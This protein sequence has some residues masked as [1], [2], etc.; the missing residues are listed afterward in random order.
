[1]AAQSPF[2]NS[3][4]FAIRAQQRNLLSYIESFD[5][6]IKDA[7]VEQN[8][9]SYEIHIIDVITPIGTEYR[10]R[11]SNKP[12]HRFNFY[13]FRT[14]LQN[15]NQYT[16]PFDAPSREVS[17][18]NASHKANTTT[19]HD[20]EKQ[21]GDEYSH[22]HTN[23]NIK[24]EKCNCEAPKNA[25]LILTFLLPRKNRDYIL[26]DLDEDFL[27]NIIPDY[28]EKIAK[29]WYWF[30]TIRTILEHNSLTARIINI[31]DAFKKSNGS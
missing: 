21:V 4:S 25:K 12:G 7:R 20:E 13:D 31:I 30:Q 19:K 15:E 16:L 28:G 10:V 24:N 29:R 11:L 27:H 17:N 5:L 23:N 2:K 22:K 3:Q 9:D 14:Q 18:A 6:L 8:S 26:G 1:M